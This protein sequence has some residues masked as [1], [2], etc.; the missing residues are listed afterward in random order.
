MG[1]DTAP[2]G[3]LH[4]GIAGARTAPLVLG[5]AVVMAVAVMSAVGLSPA[6]G[7]MFPAV[8]Q[9]HS[10]VPSALCKWHSIPM[11]SPSQHC[12]LQGIGPTVAEGEHLP[13]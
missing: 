7:H 5:G 12:L 11:G 4:L 3:A 10:S 13:P 9:T 2:L 8:P 6:W 1:L